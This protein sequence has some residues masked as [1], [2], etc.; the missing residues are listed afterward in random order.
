MCVSDDISRAP[1]LLLYRTGS[2]G[3]SR[4]PPNHVWDTVNSNL[5]IKQYEDTYILH[6]KDMSVF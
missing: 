1:L 6:Q 3:D 2:R 4:Y 5:C